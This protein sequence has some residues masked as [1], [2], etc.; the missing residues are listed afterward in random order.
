M[1]PDIEG[2]KERFARRGPPDYDCGHNAP[3][4]F[5]SGPHCGSCH[6][7]AEADLKVALAY[8]EELEAKLKTAREEGYDAGR[9]DAMDAHSC[10][11]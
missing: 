7:E 11:D 2:I 10:H 5:Q 4:D 9:D 6:P 3:D 8:I 1:K